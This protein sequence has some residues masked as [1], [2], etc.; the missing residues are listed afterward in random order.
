MISPAGINFMISNIPL[1]FN[2]PNAGISGFTQREVRPPGKTHLNAFVGCSVSL[3]MNN[4]LKSICHPFVK[5]FSSMNGS[6]SYF[7]V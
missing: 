5:A 7:S 4:L 2:M 3:G 6:Y 1:F